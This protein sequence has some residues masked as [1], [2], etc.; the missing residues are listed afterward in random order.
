MGDF[1][2]KGLKSADD[3]HCMLGRHGF[4]S[5][6]SHCYLGPDMAENAMQMEKTR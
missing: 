6:G 5:V 2:A 3:Y 4:V 1:P